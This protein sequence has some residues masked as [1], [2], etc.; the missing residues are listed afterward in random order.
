M[1]GEYEQELRKQLAELADRY[2]QEY[3]RAASPII[4]ALV[5]IE[6]CKPPKPHVFTQEQIAAWLGDKP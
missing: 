3:R 2:T 5:R 4:D 6:V 1:M